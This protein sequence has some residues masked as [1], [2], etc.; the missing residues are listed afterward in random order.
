[1]PEY[2][3]MYG[4]FEWFFAE[5][6]YFDLEFYVSAGQEEPLGVEGHG[7]SILVEWHV[8]S[9]DIRLKNNDKS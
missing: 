8:E 7:N 2:N 6:L 4:A 5:V 9:H 1:M 3:G